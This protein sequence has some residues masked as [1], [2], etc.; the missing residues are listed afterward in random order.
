MD[1]REAVA[2][3]L[4]GYRV[5]RVSVIGEGLE[6]RAFEING[7]LV[8]RVSRSPDP[9]G[10][11][12]EARLLAFVA[13]VVPVPVP[14]PVFVD[15]ERGCLAY[16]RLPG[17]PLLDLPSPRPAASIA[18][19]LGEML[20]ALHAVPAA[21][22]RDLAE[23]DDQ[24]PEEWLSEAASHYATVAGRIPPATRPRVASFLAAPPPPR[25][26]TL[27]FSHNDLGIEH[28]LADPAS[29][30]VTGVI[31]WSDAALV[32]PAC[33]FGLILRDLGPAA[34]D[35]AAGE[36]GDSLRERALFYARCAALE[37]LAYGVD[38]YVRN[39]LAAIER[40]F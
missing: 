1:A 6:H 16:P 34:F 28:V 24:P 14:A 36:R 25:G 4:P 40:L 17:T 11:A 15:L 29:W 2:A 12:R 10:L 37:D 13:P 31:D 3:N 30:A 32:D 22:V 8:V 26:E 21:R 5:D 33:D 18:P 38:K 9:A 23:V 19:V 35:V 39:A 20:A 7:E 27:V